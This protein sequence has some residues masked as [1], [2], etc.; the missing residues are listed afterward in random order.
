MALKVYRPVNVMKLLWVTA[1]RDLHRGQWNASA[2][3]FETY[4]ESFKRI[5]GPLSPHLVCFVDDPHAEPVRQMGVRVCPYMYDDTLIPKHLERQQEIL[6][7]STFRDMIPEFLRLCPEYNVAEYGLVNC[8][9][10]SFVRRASTMFPEY[11]HYAWIDF[12]YAKTPEEAPPE[13]PFVCTTLVHPD[14][15]LIASFRNALFDANGEPALGVYG[16]QTDEIAGLYN[17]NNPIKCL[18]EPPHIL[19]GNLYVV[20]KK[21]TRWLEMAMDRS[22]ERHH[23]LG[24]VRH[25]ESFFLPILHDFRNRFHLHI[26]TGADM[27]W[28]R[29]PRPDVGIRETIFRIIDRI[30]YVDEHNTVIDHRTHERNEQ[31]LAL[32]FIPRD[33]TVLELGA[34][35]GTVSC[36]INSI[37]ND[38]T[39]HVAV[40]PDLPAALL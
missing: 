38:P 10:T 28:I 8:A 9:K 18:R 7:D 4:L 25:D 40:D 16:Q 5:A 27:N 6:N 19:Q 31:E 32:R 2:R 13:S 22:I 30:P 14:K 11:T 26:K 34:R 23:D 33:A 36:V 39:R 17:W 12:G 3:T 29:T 20:P 37:L 15:I 21:Y 1:F 24:I 35:Y